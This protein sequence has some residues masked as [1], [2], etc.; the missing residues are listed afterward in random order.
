MKNTDELR[1][2]F[3]KM[4]LAA[5]HLN[6]HCMDTGY[7]IERRVSADQQYLTL[8]IRKHSDTDSAVYPEVLFADEWFGDACI[9]FEICTVGYGDH[10]IAQAERVI[11]GLTAATEFVKT[12]YATAEECGLTT[13]R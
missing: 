9:R 13:C 2:A 10:S 1:A 6:T 4:V 3:D 8:R 5:N 11:R 7:Q 12:L